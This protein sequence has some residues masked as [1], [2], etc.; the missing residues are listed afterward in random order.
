MCVR[1]CAYVCERECVCMC[2]RERVCVCVRER[3]CAYVCE[4]E[5]VCM[6]ERE[7]VCVCVR[8]DI[9]FPF[10]T[11]YHNLTTEI[12]NRKP[13]IPKQNLVMA[14]LPDMPPKTRSTSS[15]LRLSEAFISTISSP[16]ALHA[17]WANVVFPS[18]VYA[19]MSHGTR[20]NESWHTCE[21]VIAHV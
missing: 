10:H 9:H 17:T 18:P 8:V 19:Q 2:V 11:L 7:R 6:C 12:P 4:R 20:V 16:S 3:E 15:A 13:H 21:C 14:E 1:E 5:S